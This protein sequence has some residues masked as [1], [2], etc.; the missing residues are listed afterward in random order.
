MSKGYDKP[1]DWELQQDLDC[2]SEIPERI[3]EFN[4][5]R[6]KEILIYLDF[7]INQI[8]KTIDGFLL[9]NDN[10]YNYPSEYLQKN[11][12][13][14]YWAENISQYGFNYYGFLEQKK[15]IE[16][17]LNIKSF[18][19]SNTH[20]SI[21]KNDGNGLL[22]F[23]YL[24]DNFPGNVGVTTK[25]TLIHNYLRTELDTSAR[26][27]MR[28]VKEYCSKELN[29]VKFSRMA[30]EP[31]TKAKEINNKIEQSVEYYLTTQKKCE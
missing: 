13:F 11:K 21:F 24:K 25:Y 3:R 14:Q 19:N 22:I 7:R 15:R 20:E 28:F 1:K 27:Y 5:V 16:N 18:K 29:G 8:L 31:T 23:N 12:Q 9:E 6:L 4:T 30:E 10:T 17:F 26:G 2:L